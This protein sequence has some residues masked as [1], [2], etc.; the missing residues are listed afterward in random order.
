MSV[1]PTLLGLLER[2]SPSGA[3]GEAVD[4]LVARMQALGFAARV[5]KSGNAVGVLGSGPREIVLLGH[6]DTVPGEIEVR[7]AGDR[8]YGRG[9][10]DAK[11]PLAAFV[12]AAAQVGA[13]EGWRVVVIGA[14]DEERESR[15]ARHIVDQYQP[16]FAIVG[17]PSAWE[18]VTLGYKGSVRMRLRVERS[19]AHSAGA[20]E[21]AAEA[22]AASWQAIREWVSTFNEGITSPFEQMLASLQG[23]QS[24]GDGFCEWAELAL[25]FRSPP[26]WDA[27]GL[28]AALQ[29]LD[30][31]AG[32][33]LSI[34]GYPIAA[35]S[36]EKNN[37][38]VRAFLRAIRAA[39]SEPRFVRKTGTADMNVVGPAWG[40]PV[41]AY[42][43]GDS[44]LDHTP[45][46][47]ISIEEYGKSV[48][49]LAGVLRELGAS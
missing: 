24:G 13:M 41:L 6:I 36:G 30:L 11:G 37:A 34:E 25:G 45:N 8:L 18:R 31:A 48:T 22:A 14:V 26:G 33:D 47:H 35:F 32:V 23:M 3:E 46:E 27:E 44:A 16:D 38:L 43:P 19:R 20:G 49:V 12:D 5:D 15:G 1:S 9:S 2:Y 7:Q 42:G 39:G 21:T 4:F 29:A 40:C 10:V 17:E 28:I